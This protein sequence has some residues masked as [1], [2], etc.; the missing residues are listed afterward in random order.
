M[1]TGYRNNLQAFYYTV[2]NELY[3]IKNQTHPEKDIQR[4]KER[5]VVLKE[6]LSMLDKFM[7]EYC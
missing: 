5:E 6:T 1:D 4:L 3:R 2:E 7:K